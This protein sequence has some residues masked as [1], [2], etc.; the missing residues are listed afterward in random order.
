MICKI[1]EQFF[2]QNDL[3]TS[4]RWK[5]ITPGVVC[6]IWCTHNWAESFHL[7]KLV[8]CSWCKRLAWL[9]CPG[10]RKISTRTSREL[11]AAQ[12]LFVVTSFTRHAS[13]LRHEIG[14]RN[15]TFRRI[16]SSAWTSYSE[17]SVCGPNAHN[18]DYIET[19]GLFG[20]F[21]LLNWSFAIKFHIIFGLEV[22]WID[23]VKGRKHNFWQILL[24][25]FNLILFVSYKMLFFWF[26][27]KCVLKIKIILLWA[28]F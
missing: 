6:R 5:D 27:H 4:K 12:A 1:L 22:A 15:I 28:E 10:P 11:S 7:R 25:E 20:L 21:M 17:V 24:L 19:F 26:C 16:W 2:P 9:Q 3:H 8:L 18:L 13:I 23:A 14:T